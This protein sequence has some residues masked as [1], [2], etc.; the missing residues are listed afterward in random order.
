M[1]LLY[2]GGFSGMLNGMLT[3]SINSDAKGTSLYAAEV[4]RTIQDNEKYLR[5]FNGPR[6][7]EAAQKIYLTA[8]DNRD[9]RYTDITPYI[10]KLAKTILKEKEKDSAFDVYTEDGEIS[11]IFYSLREYIDIDKMDGVKEIEDRFKELYLMDTQSFMKLKTIFMIDD[12]KQVKKMTELRIKNVEFM[13]EFNSLLTVHGAHMVFPTL[14][15]FFADLDVLCSPAGDTLIK[16][17][18]I[19]KKSMDLASK[20]PDIPLIKDKDGNLHHINKE[21]LTMAINPDYV[22]WDVVNSVCDILKIDMSLLLNYIY[23]E[24]YGDKGVNTRH[25]TWCGDKYK[26]TTPGGES[27]I[28]LDKEK[29]ITVVRNELILNLISSN[30]NTIIA[31]SPDIL[32]FKPTRVFQFNTLRLKLTTGKIIDI[33]IEVH[34]KKRR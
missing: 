8:I 12:V 31:I 13:Q 30:I 10:K 14:N 24:I 15:K 23:E 22:K 32:Y 26:L 5:K 25:I 1:L 11:P 9:T 18:S 34:I 33:P 27:F 20:L 3:F 6:W 2:R 17:V 16:E 7:Q 4:L 21:T 29:F 19:K 28:G